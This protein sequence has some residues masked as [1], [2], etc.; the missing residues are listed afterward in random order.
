MISRPVH[1]GG[2]ITQVC[3]TAIERVIGQRERT[4]TPSAGKDRRRPKRR[5]LFSSLT[6]KMT[7]FDVLVWA[8][9]IVTCYNFLS[10]PRYDNNLT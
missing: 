9:Y 3:D 4:S 1:T 6:L 7:N 5:H 2:R 8:E 10:G